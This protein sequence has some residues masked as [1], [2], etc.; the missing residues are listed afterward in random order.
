MS[1]RPWIAIILA[2]ALSAPAITWAQAP[3]SD[4]LVP[5]PVGIGPR[6]DVQTSA[7][8]TIDVSGARGGD[9]DLTG[10]NLRGN[11]GA[12][13]LEPRPAMPPAWPGA[14]GAG[15]AGLR[16]PTTSDFGAGLAPRDRESSQQTLGS[17]A[18][19]LQDLILPR[20]RHDSPSAA[21]NQLQDRPDAWRYRYFRDRWWY[22][23]SPGGWLI[24]NGT[25]WQPR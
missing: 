5:G 14:G 18:A 12:S 21:G 2:G 6:T 7:N 22:W 24:W 1:M 4:P 9:L 23:Q 15:P 17:S 10:G 20:F 13:R 8:G 3:G 19:G 25:A 11:L 16:F